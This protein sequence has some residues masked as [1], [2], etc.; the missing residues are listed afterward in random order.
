MLDIADDADFYFILCLFQRLP[1]DG[2]FVAP[3]LFLLLFFRYAFLAVFALADAAAMRALID[4]DLI[5]RQRV[6]PR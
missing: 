4:A 5:A 6:A 2:A 3:S 1:P